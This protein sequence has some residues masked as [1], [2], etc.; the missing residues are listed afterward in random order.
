MNCTKKK[1]TVRY[2]FQAPALMQTNSLFV[3]IGII[4]FHK[5]FNLQTFKLMLN[6]FREFEVDHSSFT[7]LSIVHNHNTRHSNNNNFVV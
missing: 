3:K 2:V 4:K 7:P 6:T 5:V 1:T